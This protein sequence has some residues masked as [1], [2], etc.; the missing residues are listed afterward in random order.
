MHSL[1]SRPSAAELC[2]LDV[3]EDIAKNVTNRTVPTGATAQ[4]RSPAG[5]GLHP[6][7]MTVRVRFAPS[8]TGALHLGGLR[9]ALYNY[10]TARRLG[11]TFTLRIED[12]DQT[13]LVS[14]S[15][16]D[17]VDGLKWAGIDFDHGPGVGG[18]HKPYVQ[19]ERLDLY[20]QYARKLIDVSLALYPKAVFILMQELVISIQSG[21]AYRCFCK[22]E[23]LAATRDRLFKL[24]SNATYDRTCLHLSDEEVARRVRAGDQHVVRLNDTSIPR[25][26]QPTKDLVFG[27]LQDGHGSLPTDPILLKSDSFPTYHLA[28]VVDDHEMQIT[29]VIR[30]EEWLQS[31]PLHVD[32]YAALGLKAPQFAHLPLLLNPDGSKMSKRKGDVKV[33]DYIKKGWEPEAVTNWLALAGW[34]VNLTSDSSKGLDPLL[35]V[36]AL[37]RQQMIEMF[38]LSSLTHRRSILD[39]GKLESLNKHHLQRKITSRCEDQDFGTLLKRAE[40]ILGDAYPTSLHDLHDPALSA[41]FFQEPDLTCA[42]ARKLKTTVDVSVYTRVIKAVTQNVR[43]AAVEASWTTEDFRGLVKVIQDSDLEGLTTKDVM[44]T[45]RHALT[46]SKVGPSVAE[47]M[48]ILGPVRCLE[49]LDVAVSFSNP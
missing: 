18:P 10:L 4:I 11:G 28:S 23:V 24:R 17:I 38:D 42:A 32:L 7:L 34:G 43:A 36:G 12:T 8:P 44:N 1:L 31:L 21:S 48:T 15:V 13:R 46:G 20:R 30:G 16:E 5:P 22:P 41:Y 3:G 47:I 9:T 27:T 49:R 37:S 45:L 35:A 6:T 39:P 14:G 2:M 26:E 29:H 33:S 25:Q 19:S 40:R